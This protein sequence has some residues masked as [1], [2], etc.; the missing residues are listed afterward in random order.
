MTK[1]NYLSEMQAL[2]FRASMA[3]TALKDEKIK[4]FYDKAE[5]DYYDQVSKIPVEEAKENI[6]QSQIEQYLRTKDFVEQ[7]ER[8][9]A[10]ACSGKQVDQEAEECKFVKSLF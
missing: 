6:T 3:L 10:E 2:C 4:V 5:K 8:E 1:Y 9:A 7:K